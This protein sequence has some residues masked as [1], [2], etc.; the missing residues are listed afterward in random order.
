[1]WFH[2]FEFVAYIIFLKRSLEIS[3]VLKFTRLKK[4][5]FAFDVHNCFSTLRSDEY[6]ASEA[7]IKSFATA[8]YVE[9]DC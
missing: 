4:K 9:K 1:M 3:V 5:Y 6:L 7:L 2:L 8:E